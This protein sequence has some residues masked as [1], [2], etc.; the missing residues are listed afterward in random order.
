MASNG[1][2]RPATGPAAN[3]AVESW[4]EPEVGAE[5]AL[6]PEA[7][8]EPEPETTVPGQVARAAAEHGAEF[9]PSVLSLTLTLYRAMT[10]FDRAGA[11][12][13][14]P[15]GLN[16]SQFN[17]LTVLHRADGPLTMGELGLA[18]SVRPAN[19]TSVVDSLVQRSL[20]ERRVNPGD[21]RSYLIAN[22]PAG[23]DFLGRFLPGHWRYLEALTGHLT[24]AERTALTELLDRLRLS[25]EAAPAGQPVE[26][27]E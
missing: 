8:P 23:E 3:D 1:R 12:E 22:T 11:A 17:V 21:R 10:A 5:P 24:S 27:A 13:L 4:S 7:E 2:R 16:V 26:M 19:L 9:D 25:V 15:H 18:V 6:Q 20:I 14:A